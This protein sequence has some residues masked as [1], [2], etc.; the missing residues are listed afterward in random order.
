MNFPGF[1]ARLA[2]CFCF[3]LCLTV[4]CLSVSSCASV[5]KAREVQNTDS[6]PAGERTLVGAEVGLDT[7]TFLTLDRALQIALACQ[8]SL[9][10]ASQ[11]VVSAQAQLRSA[12]SS[13]WP[14]LNAG[15]SYSRGT[16][17]AK[18][19]P[20]NN[21]SD[22]S[23]R[24]ALS[25][26][27]VLFD[28]GKT[29]AV[30]RQA[31]ASAIAAEC[32]LQAT[33]NNIG[34]EVS[35]AF[36]EL[37]KAE[38]LFR[39]AEEAIRQFQAHL[40]QVRTF[41]EVGRRTRYDITKAEVDLGNAQLDL[42]TVSNALT[43]T[44]GV[45]NRSL[46]LAEDPG[47]HIVVPPAK[48]FSGEAAA[49]MATARKQHPELLAL[50]AAE[51]VSSAAV[52]E[53]IASLYPSLNLGAEYVVAGAG[54]PLTWNWGA[55]VQSVLNL[56]NGFRSTAAIDAAAAQLRIARSKRAELEQHIYLDLTRA[57]SQL[58]SA[59][60]RL[61][62]DALIVRQA[63]ESLDLISE[64]YRIG[65]A[66]SVE[67]TDAQVALT[68]AQAD[69]VKARFDYQIAIAQIKHAFGEEIR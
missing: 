42:I 27:Y 47:Y 21:H 15:A 64:R 20:E 48:E 55:S 53:A 41:A 9:F 56:F 63:R 44:R 37:G 52:D 40:D 31:Y 10:Q 57:L 69:L 23:Y 68:S 28:F 18:G 36:F 51:N 22:N 38:E 35:T 26:D 3:S 46:G 43:I 54:F 8:P 30:V 32:S 45:L 5:R 50:I 24:G 13:Y 34:M 6:R 49:L 1:S 11:N 17:N 39:V 12:K 4:L 67:V 19:S 62:L 25:L 65:K 61:L 60:Q 16:S 29:P 33:R 14:S 66:S 59:H 2:K 7:N 58:N